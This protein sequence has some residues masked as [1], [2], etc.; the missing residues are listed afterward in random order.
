MS[1]YELVSMSEYELVGMSEYEQAPPCL[2]VL[3][4][5]SRCGKAYIT[6]CMLL[7]FRSLAV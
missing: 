6:T 1:E 5:V 2:G 7:F 4:G 3:V